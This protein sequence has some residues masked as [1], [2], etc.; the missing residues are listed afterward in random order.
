MRRKREKAMIRCIRSNHREI[1]E[2]GTDANGTSIHLHRQASSRRGWG[3][4]AK[5]TRVKRS[6]NQSPP[7]GEGAS[8][9]HDSEDNVSSTNHIFTGDIS[10]QNA[11]TLEDLDIFEYFRILDLES[12]DFVSESL[13]KTRPD[14]STLSPHEQEQ[15]SQWKLLQAL[16]LRLAYLRI[17]FYH[18]N[19]I[20]KYDRPEVYATLRIANFGNVLDELKHVP[21]N[22]QFRFISTLRAIARWRDT[23]QWARE[24]IEAVKG[25]RLIDSTTRKKFL[26]ILQMVV[27]AS[28]A[29]GRPE[30]PLADDSLDMEERRRMPIKLVRRSLCYLDQSCR[31]HLLEAEASVAVLMK[32]ILGSL[33]PPEGM[34]GVERMSFQRTIK[35][36]YDFDKEKLDLVRAL[37]KNGNRTT[38]K[39]TEIRGLLDRSSI[40]RRANGS[41]TS[42]SSQQTSP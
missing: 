27:S 1:R 38:V 31:V 29:N 24:A 4:Y 25:C 26:L 37:Y 17:Q 11:E 20:H 41:M 6:S 34:D 39:N 7:S 21:K 18:R 15:I 36:Q 2:V 13:I 23:L 9:R 35:S 19:S 42:K 8:P 5:K 3:R 40:L 16:Q 22:E 32:S 14:N 12:G 28:Q 10:D 33:T 30:V